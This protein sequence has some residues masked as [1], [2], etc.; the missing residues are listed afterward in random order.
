M[1]NPTPVN[2]NDPSIIFAQPAGRDGGPHWHN[3]HLNN[4]GAM[5]ANG[6][7]GKS[8][9]HTHTHTDGGEHCVNVCG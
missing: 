8:G 4:P 1:P 3:H 7:V 5:V 2:L 6:T 9:T